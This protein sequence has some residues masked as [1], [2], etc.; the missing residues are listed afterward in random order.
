[1]A[2]KTKPKRKRDVQT[3][4]RIVIVEEFPR[5]AV[6]KWA[7][8]NDKWTEVNITPVYPFS[9]AEWLRSMKAEGYEIVSYVRDK[10]IREALRKSGAPVD[11]H[12]RG[13]YTIW[14]PTDE[15]LVVEDR[16]DDMMGWYVTIDVR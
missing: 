3:S 10:K 1:M 8:L 4:K 6:D 15:F 5:H 12:Y 14:R 2:V 16:G 7:E 11:K 9:V 13:Q